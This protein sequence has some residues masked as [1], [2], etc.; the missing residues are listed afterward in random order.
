MKI[1]CLSSKSNSNSQTS[2]K[3]LSGK[4]V[5]ST[6]L[7]KSSTS[8]TNFAWKVI[9]QL[10]SKTK[11]WSMQSSTFT[12]TI[13]RGP[14]TVKML[15][16]SVSIMLAWKCWSQDS[17]TSGTEHSKVTWMTT[18]KLQAPFSDTTMTC[19]ASRFPDLKLS[20]WWTKLCSPTIFST[21]TQTRQIRWKF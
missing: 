20:K 7:T 4:V 3:W 6:K 17:A 16:T 13:S 18:I 19:C 14:R 2:I 15:R 8:S 11:I 10:R 1:S 12:N 9:S 21:L 5:R